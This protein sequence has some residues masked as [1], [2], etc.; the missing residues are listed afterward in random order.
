MKFFIGFGI[1]TLNFIFWNIQLFQ[2]C[3]LNNLSSIFFNYNR[4]LFMLKC[5]IISHLEL[6]NLALWRSQW[7]FYNKLLNHSSIKMHITESF[8][9][10]LQSIV[11][12][13]NLNMVQ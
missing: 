11:S 10:F 3:S 5:F 8:H 7:N 4:S 2:R 13:F 1:V 12:L 6:I 9:W